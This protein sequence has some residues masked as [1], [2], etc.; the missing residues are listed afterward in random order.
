[1]AIKHGN[2]LVGMLCVLGYLFLLTSTL[3]VFKQR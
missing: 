2:G 1:M 3:D